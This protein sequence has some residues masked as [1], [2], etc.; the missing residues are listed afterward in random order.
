MTVLAAI[1]LYWLA[2]LGI[3]AVVWVTAVEVA[4][5]LRRIKVRRVRAQ[6]RAGLIRY[7]AASEA[8]GVDREWE[9]AS[10]T[11]GHGR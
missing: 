7:V 10:Q 6:L 9:Q 2:V 4:C 3:A 5:L 11:W 8:R 1:G